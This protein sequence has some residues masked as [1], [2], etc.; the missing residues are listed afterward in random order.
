MKVVRWDHADRAD[1]LKRFDREAQAMQRITSPFV[2][3]IL[4]TGSDGPLRFIV[5]P[6]IGGPS[7]QAFVTGK[8]PLDPARVRRLAIGIATAMN[9]M[10][11]EG[12]VHRDLKP[13]NVI[14]RA[15]GEPVVIDLGIAKISDASTLTHFPIGTPGYIAPEVFE[16]HEAGAAADVFSWAATTVF[17]AT[18]RKC[19]EGGG[20]WSLADCESRLDGVPEG[21]LP[22]VRRALGKDPESRPTVQEL[23]NLDGAA[24]GAGSRA[25]AVAATR[26]DLP[27]ED[28][29]YGRLRRAF[30]DAISSNDLDK[31]RDAAGEFRRLAMHDADREREV[32][33]LLLLGEAEMAG[34]REDEAAGHHRRALRIAEHLGNEPLLGRCRKA[35]VRCLKAVA[36]RAPLED[37]PA[38][39]EELLGLA[40][41]VDDERL[42]LL[43]YLKGGP[44]LRGVNWNRVLEMAER[45]GE[46]TLIME[47]LRKLDSV[48]DCERLRKMAE[49][50][51]DREAEVESLLK[52][53]RHARR[54]DDP[55]RTAWACERA[56]EISR[57]SRPLR[58]G[59]GCCASWYG[60]PVRRE[61]TRSPVKAGSGC[62]RRSR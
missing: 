32:E 30:S 5:T 46:P 52:L 34:Q 61:W 7:L 2:A 3:P 8:G 44:H 1:V 27:A 12:V 17:A 60:R 11:E 33:A 19:F 54:Q 4:D 48:E 22:L 41:A 40:H 42:A 20:K 57:G 59:S 45:V 31:A 26:S 15:N 56:L 50:L 62:L 39:Y 9:A 37:R 55:G 24:A 53:A 14:V 18:G 51:G 47:V 6:Y 28:E 49:E 23:I 16:G 35:L 38:L 58:P 21:L 25:T 10:H 29:R 13:G 36:P 43:C